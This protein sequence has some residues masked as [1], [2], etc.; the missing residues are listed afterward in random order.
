MESVFQQL[1]IIYFAMTITS[2][3]IG[4]ESANLPS[5]DREMSPMSTQHVISQ[6]DEIIKNL[7]KRVENLEVCIHLQHF[8]L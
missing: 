5:T 4:V 3:G 2:S 8:W 7:T 1:C 6:Q